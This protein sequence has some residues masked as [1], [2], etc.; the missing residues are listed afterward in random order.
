MER[1]RAVILDLENFPVRGFAWTQREKYPTTQN[2]IDVDRPWN[3]ASFAW[4]FE[5][6]KG[7]PQCL[8]LPDFPKAYKKNPFDDYQL[9]LRLHAILDEADLV[10]GHNV[11]SFDLRKT[12]A[13]LIKYGIRPPSPYRVYDTLTEARSL[14]MFPSNKLGDLAKYLCCLQ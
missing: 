12:V 10:I 4:K 13:R 5:G 7:K 8:A 6:D 2:L 11:R 3:I 1:Y 9:L 14:G